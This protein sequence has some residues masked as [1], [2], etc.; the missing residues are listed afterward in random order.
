M[1]EVCC[2]C[3]GSSSGISLLEGSVWSSYCLWCLPYFPGNPDFS[4]AEFYTR[5]RPW[6][7]D[8]VEVRRLEAEEW[9]RGL[10]L[11]RVESLRSGSR[12]VRGR[13]RGGFG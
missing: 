7:D 2:S 10:S 3:S 5:F 1:S 12:R 9:D 13:F 11:R 4:A 6:L 8:P